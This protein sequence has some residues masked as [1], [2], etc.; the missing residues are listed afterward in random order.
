MVPPGVVV[1]RRTPYGEGVAYVIVT[2]PDVQ[3]KPQAERHP[4]QLPERL[5]VLDAE[6]E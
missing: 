6:V 4:A 5:L 3:G 1:E 2:K